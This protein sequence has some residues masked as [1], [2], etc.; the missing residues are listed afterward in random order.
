MKG[1]TMHPNRTAC[2]VSSALLLLT[3]GHA[4]ARS[5]AD[6]H[7]SERFAG[8]SLEIRNVNGP[9]SVSRSGN[10]M[11]TVTAVRTADRSDPESVRIRVT[12]DRRGIVICAQ[13]PDDDSSCTRDGGTHYNNNQTHAN[14]TTVAFKIE[15]PAGA[16]AA[17]HDVNG[18]IEASGLDSPIDAATVNGHINISTSSYAQAK[19]VN[20]SIRVSMGSSTWPDNRLEFA[21]VNG[22]IDVTV[23]KST[24]AHV[25]LKTLNGAI[26]SNISL[27]RNDGVFGIMHRAEGVIGSGRGDL[28]FTTVNGSISLAKGS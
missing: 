8:K 7:F 14:D 6:I 11:L 20:G 23:P 1:D 13:Y 2:V 18:S 17:L 12:H 19:T 15:L 3:A 9:I 28:Q 27:E 10:D 4:Q 5:S 16:S 24:S 26:H 22:A 25:H 21:S